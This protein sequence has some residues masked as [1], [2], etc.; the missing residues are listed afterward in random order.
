MSPFKTLK[1]LLAVLWCLSAVS[2][3]KAQGN[4]SSG[5]SVKSAMDALVETYFDE[6]ARLSPI[7]ATLR[8]DH[9]FDALMN[10]VSAEGRAAR[11]ASTRKTL[12]ALNALNPEDLSR[13][14]QIDRALMKHRLEYALWQEETLQEWAWNPL[15]YSGLAGNAIYSLTARDFAPLKIRLQSAISRLEQ[16]PR[17]YE[18][19]RDVLQPKRVPPIHAETAIQQNAGV[20]NIIENT[21][22]PHMDE[23]D[24]KDQERL[25]QAIALARE[26]VKEQ[27]EWLEKELLPN[28]QGNFRLGKKLYDQK[29]S[30]TLQS[31]LTREQIRDRGREQIRT[32]HARMYA[33]AQTIYKGRYPYTQFPEDPSDAYRRA[34]I[35]A[36]LEMA[37]QD[38]PSADRVVDAANESVR[39]TVDFLR[40]KDIITLPDDPMEIIVMPEFRRGVSLAYCDSPGPMEVGLKTFY[41]VSPPP[42]SWSQDQV[43][44]HLREYNHRSLHNLTIHEAYPGHFVQLAHANRTPRML[45][46]VL[47]SGSFIEGWAVYSEWMMCEEGFLEDD[48]LMRLIVL[49]WYLRDVINAL[50]DQAVHV[51]GISEQE[52]MRLLTEDAF[53]EEREAAGKWRRA[54]LTAAQLSTY[55]VGYLEHVDLR[56]EAEKRW[57]DRFD[58][59]TYH[60]RALSFG[61]LPTQY[62]RTLLFDLDL[63][64]HGVER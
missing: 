57:G 53:Q 2:S 15:R 13:D 36:C 18:Q 6:S 3:M 35:R 23:L 32:L 45:R 31:P 41:A 51:D 43:T 61:S 37:Y 42:A 8:G 44:S 27:Q 54:L 7:S 50:L 58:L 10:D 39:L 22:Q 12:A 14:D 46:A 40:K 56:A 29:L 47:G 25:K 34:I 28:A 55:Y 4:A 5:A 17:L 9:R 19:V 16:L 30:W 11:L 49:K 64:F 62:V 48:L 20:L 52:A 21:I 1:S 33:M 63:P 38:R 59:K 24:A 60:D 26:A